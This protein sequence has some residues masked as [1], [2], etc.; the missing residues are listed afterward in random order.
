M[1]LPGNKPIKILLVIVMVFYTVN[2]SARNN[3]SSKKIHKSKY[4]IAQYCDMSRNKIKKLEKQARRKSTPRIQ[5]CKR[6]YSELRYQSC[7]MKK[8][9]DKI[10]KAALNCKR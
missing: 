5:R 1:S 6:A 9:K 10:Y 3:K 8:Y 2:F 4:Q 7:H